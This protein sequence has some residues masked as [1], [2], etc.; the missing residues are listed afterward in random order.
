MIDALRT[1]F[2]PAAPAIPEYQPLPEYAILYF[3]HLAGEWDSIPA[4][5]IDAEAKAAVERIFEK[6]KVRDK[7]KYN[8]DQKDKEEE[9]K[10]LTWRDLY[11]FDLLLTRKQPLEKLSRKVWSLRSRYRDVAGL[12]EYEAYLASKPPDLAATTKEEELRADI[13]FL[14]GELYLRYAIMPIRE[15]VRDQITGKVAR[16]MFFAIMLVVLSFYASFNASSAGRISIEMAMV[17][18]VLFSGAV[19]GL[20]SMQQR[21]QSVPSEGDQIDSVSE[22]AHGFLTTFTPL[23]SGAIFA[24]ILFFL[25]SAGWLK[26]ELF[27]NT[28]GLF[29]KAH[30][31]FDFLGTPDYAKLVIWSFVAGFAERFVPDT[32][33]RF[34]EKR[35]TDSV[36]KS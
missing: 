21:Y 15:K 22:L 35:V 17:M 19:G 12:K 16:Y 10:I 4:D 31:F 9:G 34:L 30:T 3:E 6:V 24:L 26:G 2:F 29:R 7:S 32:L 13:E 11:T 5:R 1:R 36:A 33:S 25:I 14:L 8:K 28:E 18:I 27:P 23:F 20:V